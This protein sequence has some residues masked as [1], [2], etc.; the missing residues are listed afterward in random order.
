MT[1]LLVSC[2]NEDKAQPY[3]EALRGV[4]VPADW[5]RLVTPAPVRPEDAAALAAGAAGL[6]LCGGPDLEPHHYG[7]E[8]HPHANL[9]LMPER[10]AV[11]L[12]LLAGARE[13]KTPTFGVCRGLQMTNAFLGGTLWQD[14]KLMWPNAVLHDLSFP[15]DALIHPVAVSP[16]AGELGE[17]L[18]GDEDSG[19]S[20]TTL[21][22]SRHHQ[23]IKQLAPGLTAVAVAPDGI[24]EAIAGTDPGWWLWGVQWHP[25]NLVDLAPQRR[26]FERFRDQVEERA[27]QLAERAHAERGAAEPALR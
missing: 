27:L 26:L 9:G 15:R 19:L 13:A 10:D 4:G 6:L 2:S 3:V 12:A 18:G 11:E 14:L 21:V 1:D 8:P 20:G 17:I 7:E 23:A 22:N 5:I 24:V 16:G 25:E